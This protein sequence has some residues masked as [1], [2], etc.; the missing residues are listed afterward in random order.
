[1]RAFLAAV[2]TCIVVA[3][4]ASYVLEGFQRTTES[5]NTTIGTRLGK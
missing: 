2:V 5:S 4:A 3:V 1:M